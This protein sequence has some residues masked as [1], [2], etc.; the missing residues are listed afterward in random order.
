[1]AQSKAACV[2]SPSASR[3]FDASVQHGVSPF[4]R[5]VELVRFERVSH[6]CHER[7]I[8]SAE[9]AVRAVS[10][11][12]LHSPACAHWRTWIRLWCILRYPPGL[13]LWVR[14]KVPELTSTPSRELQNHLTAWR[15]CSRTNWRRRDHVDYMLKTARRYGDAAYLEAV[16]LRVPQEVAVCEERMIFSSLVRPRADDDE[17]DEIEPPSFM[18]PFVVFIHFLEHPHRKLPYFNTNTAKASAAGYAA[19]DGDLRALKALHALGAPLDRAQD[20]RTWGAASAQT[21][22]E[23]GNQTEILEWMQSLEK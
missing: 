4:L 10:T 12:T 7:A 3:A 19:H 13:D 21:E 17:D 8:E 16:L 23:F 5:P 1:M 6:I 11:V 14:G 9:A 22:A 2:E 20:A 15:G 18:Q